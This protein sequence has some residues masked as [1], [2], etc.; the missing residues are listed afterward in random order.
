MPEQKNSVSG[1]HSKN[2]VFDE[3]PRQARWRHRFIKRIGS[4]GVGAWLFSHIAHRVDM[5]IIRLSKGKYSLTGLLS[6]LPI[7]TLTVIGAKS[8]EPR[9]VPL[10]A[11]PSGDEVVLIAS[12]F[13]R[14]R[15]PAW[16][17]NLR[18]NPQATLSTKGQTGTY[19]AYEAEGAE[20]EKRWRQAVAYY[21]GFAA[22][23]QR[24]GNRRIPVMVLTPTSE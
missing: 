12:S 17:H 13:G 4:S 8:G 7:I 14:S 6:G 15:H 2:R 1:I 18:A 3:L 21:L 16:F 11:I 9:V 24:A 19:I 22:Y 23:Q 5:P 20:R 10:V